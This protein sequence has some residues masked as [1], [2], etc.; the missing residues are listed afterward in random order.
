MIYDRFA[1]LWVSEKN[2]F[3]AP[4]RYYEND[5]RDCSLEELQK[6]KN[7]NT[8]AQFDAVIIVPTEEIH[9]SGYRCMKFILQR[10][11]EIV[12]CVSGWSDVIHPN[13][14][15]NKGREWPADW[16]LENSWSPYMGLRMDCLP[17]SNCIRLM[18]HGVF[19]VADFIGS[20]F[21]FFKIPEE[22]HER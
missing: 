11:D 2:P 22:Q 3:A 17:G 8:E 15:G 19:K 20:D 13:G 4:E 9:D 14:I 21:Q 5:A 18:M 7:Y 10:A 1:Q 16:E 12:G 6:L